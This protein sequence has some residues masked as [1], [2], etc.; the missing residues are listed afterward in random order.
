MGPEFGEDAGTK[1]I[2]VRALYG[3]K[4]SRAA[5]RNHLEDCMHHLGFLTCPSDQDIWMK[6]M[7]RHGGGF[8]YYAYVL[9]YVDDFM[10]IHNDADSLLRMIDKYFKL[11]T[12]SI[13]EPYIYLGAKL[14]K[15][16]L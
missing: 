4:S 15:I 2:V 1:S 8:N 12:S 3:L 10:F 14:E 6:P 7:I 11:K 5:F 16:I 9:I 13:G